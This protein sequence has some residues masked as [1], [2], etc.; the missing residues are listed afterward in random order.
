MSPLQL[1][2]F[3]LRNV[4][5]V[6]LYRRWSGI[7]IEQYAARFSHP[8]MR[9]MF[10][11]IF[12]HHQFF[13]VLSLMVALGWM[14][15]KSAGYPIGGSAGFIDRLLTRYQQLGGEVLYHK[16]VSSILLEGKTA[17]GVQCADATRYEADIVVASGDRHALLHRLL[18][19]HVV[20]PKMLRPFET[21]RVLPSIVQ[22]SLGVKR[23]FSEEP[24]KMVLPLQQPLP[25]GADSASVQLLRICNFDSCF[26]PAGKTAFV[27]HLRTTDAHYWIALRRDDPARYR[28]EKERVAEVVV[29]DLCR[30]FGLQRDQIEQLD[31]ATPATYVRY[32]GV[33]QGS[34]QAWA[35]TP[36]Y[37]GKSLSKTVPGIKNL[38]M[39]GQW[40]STPGGLPRVI[41]LGRQ[42]TQ[43]I[44]KHFKRRFSVQA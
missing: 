14:H 39:C 34:Y 15:K 27:S 2:L 31:V 23:S 6:R 24:K 30:R 8:A 5:M 42:V 17:R 28:A 35:P 19:L 1:M 18:P 11:Q 3:P 36:E 13:S 12:P 41:V 25:M 4:R 7:S 43:L 21:M 37:I 32:T 10:K 44:C 22:V 26:A 9:Q 33:Y 20:P 29:A 38:Y 16:K 40:L